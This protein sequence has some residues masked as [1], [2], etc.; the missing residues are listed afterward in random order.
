ML[1]SFVIPLFNEEES[2]ETLH[3]KISDEM[4]KLPHEHEIIFVD[5]GSTDNSYAEIKKICD[6]VPYTKVVKFRRNFGKSIAL[7]EGFKHTRGDIIFTMDADLQD[8]PKEIPRFI[9]ELEKGYDLVSGWKKKRKDPVFT[10]NI[11]SKLFNFMTSLFSGLKLHDFNCGLKAYRFTLAK[12]LR[13]YGDLHR[14]ISAIAHSM[15]FKVTEIPIEHHPRTYGASK[16]GIE[17]F[18]HGMLDFITIV[19]L[20]RFLKKPMHL[21]G[22]FGILFS[23]SGFAICFY[24]TILWFSGEGIGHRPL[25]FLGILLILA[26]IQLFST[27]LIAEMITHSRHYKGK[28][29]II[30]VK[31]GFS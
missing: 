18:F 12:Q 19:F 21:F 26:G 14:Y 6:R 9:S 2:I 28:D 25:L 3:K 16:Y 8:D 31:V 11:P 7:D 15:G 29:D 22:I 4:N 1:I 27:G 23:L 24:L 5:D 20:I 10:K 17:R 13:L 30:E